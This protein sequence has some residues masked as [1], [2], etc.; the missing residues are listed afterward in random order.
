M[1]TSSLD[2]LD[3]A[4]LQALVCPGQLSRPRLTLLPPHQLFLSGL[5][6]GM[7]WVWVRCPS[8]E[9]ECHRIDTMYTLCC[10]AQFEPSVERLVELVCGSIK[11]ARTRFASIIVH[12][13]WSMLHGPCIFTCKVVLIV[14]S[15]VRARDV[16][17][18]RAHCVNVEQ[19]RHRAR[20][21]RSCGP[22][23]KTCKCRSFVS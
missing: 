1:G 7:R 3:S 18:M 17:L 2:S 22:A 14:V 8:S 15:G 5:I 4:C 21:R 9:T 23:R 13:G 10:L 6:Q 16:R 19:S 12:G 20:A 11:S